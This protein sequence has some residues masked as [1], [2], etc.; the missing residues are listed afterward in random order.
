MPTQADEF[1]YKN[2]V[3]WIHEYPDDKRISVELKRDF[4][5]FDELSPQDKAQRV[6]VKSGVQH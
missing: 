4:L 6:I 1:L 2:A 5:G 3:E